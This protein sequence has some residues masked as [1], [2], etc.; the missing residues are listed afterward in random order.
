MAAQ[1]N[2]LSEAEAIQKKASTPQVVSGVRTNISLTKPEKEFYQRF[3]NLSVNE[4]PLP[5]GDGMI[6]ISLFDDYYLFTIYDEIDNEDTPIDLS[7][8]GDLYLNFI[9]STDEIDILNHTQVDEIDLAQGQILF[10]ITRSNSKKILALDN[11]NFYISSKMVDPTDGSTSDETVLY[12]GVWLAVDDANRITLTRQ[13]EEARVEYSILLGRLQTQIDQLTKDKAELFAS[14]QEDEATIIRLQNSS[15]ELVDEIGELTKDLS[16]SKVR[17]INQRAKA[18]QKYAELQLKKRQQID[19]LK[20][21]FIKAGTKAKKVEY[22]KNAAKNLQNFTVG[23][24]S[25]TKNVVE[26][27]RSRFDRFSGLFGGRGRF[28]RFY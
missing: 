28:G 14:A 7:N 11:N 8:V 22:Y 9:G 23:K 24:T 3:V 25:I 18:A 12:Q 6:R 5:Q 17:L 4:Q 1:K 26:D 15:N 19:A 10:R 27:D 2:R 16:S 20:K 21:A 13:I